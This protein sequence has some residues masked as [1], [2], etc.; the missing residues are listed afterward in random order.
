MDPTTLSKGDPRRT[1]VGTRVDGRCNDDP[2]DSGVVWGS[3][4]DTEVRKGRSCGGGR[5]LRDSRRVS[6]RGLSGTKGSPGCND[7]PFD[8]GAVLGSRKETEV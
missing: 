1:K 8:S 3:W 7:D 2:F 5:G 4:K 6:E